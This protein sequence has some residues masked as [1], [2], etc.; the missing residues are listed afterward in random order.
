MGGL[1]EHSFTLSEKCCRLRLTR[2]KTAAGL[3]SCSMCKPAYQWVSNDASRVILICWQRRRA[4]LVLLGV[5]RVS[6]ASLVNDQEG[7]KL[8]GVGSMMAGGSCPTGQTCAYTCV[9][10]TRSSHPVA[11]VQEDL[12]S[13][14]SKQQ[15]PCATLASQQQHPTA[16]QQQHPTAAAAAMACWQLECIQTLEGH[17]DRVWH[18]AWS[19]DGATAAHQVGVS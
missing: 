5:V 11:L 17:T 18:L 14:V 10:M 13:S 16:S 8:A 7:G 3:A 15:Q 1:R 19:P 12:F 4:R 6:G 9:Q 2:A